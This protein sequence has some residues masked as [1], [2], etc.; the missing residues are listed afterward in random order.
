MKN[1]WR[2]CQKMAGVLLMIGVLGSCGG[3]SH[4]NRSVRYAA[5]S[6]VS[7]GA[8][9]ASHVD[10]NL[11][12]GWG[13]AFNPS[14][15]V[16]VADNKTSVST[17]YDGNGVPQS[18][19]V[20]IPAGAGGDAAPTG[21]VFNTSN[22]FF[23]SQGGL[24][25]KS[26]FIFVGEAGTLSAWSPTVNRTNAVTVVDTG[27]GG[28]V[29]KGLALASH[30]GASYLYAADFRQR[31]IDVYDGAFNRVNLPGAFIDPALP[32]DYTP[33][34]VAARGDRIYVTYAQFSAPNTDENVGAGL[35]IV[36]LF[37]SGGNFI[38]R[39]VTG[40][41]LNAP[42]GMAFAPADFP[43]FPSALLVGN[44][45]DGMINAYD[46]D[47]G[48]FLGTLTGSGTAPLIMDGLWGIAFGNGLNNQPLTTLFF[49][50]GP[51]DEANGV[52]GRIDALP[53]Q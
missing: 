1:Q 47:T 25:G 12:N 26:A 8:L 45:G 2:H 31:R 27:A 43:G 15:F 35:G 3:S 23:V 52:Y 16:W 6:L 18:L 39:L 21:I 32:A 19:V 14:G 4:V 53:A 29:Y 7:D 9:A 40:G 44:F 20:A 24:S 22:D 50:A 28:A 48:A 42:W 46:P 51:N 11:K 30:A 13:I 33:F 41:K 38:G 49:A 10:A 36:S 5:T 37:D 17:L 34:N